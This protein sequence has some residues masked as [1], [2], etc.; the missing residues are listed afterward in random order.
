MGYSI[1]DLRREIY[2]CPKGGAVG[3]DYETYAD[4]FPPGEP[5][6]RA[7]E[8]ALGFAR[9]LGCT[10]DNRPAERRVFFVTAK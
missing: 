5:D 9:G 8:R 10:I 2:A 6:D 7:R 3:L 1:D 4:L